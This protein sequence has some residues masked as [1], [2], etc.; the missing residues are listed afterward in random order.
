MIPL[1]LVFFAHKSIDVN[2]VVG[3]IGIG[4]RVGLQRGIVPPHSLQG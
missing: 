4:I 3:H 1:G 2:G